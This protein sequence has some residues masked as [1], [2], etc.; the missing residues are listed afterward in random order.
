L[1]PEGKIRVD[2]P[3]GIEVTEEYNLWPIAAPPEDRSLSVSTDLGWFCEVTPRDLERKLHYSGTCC[4]IFA[5]RL[6][7]D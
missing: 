6:A 7:L 1:P 3:D 5:R 4:E 2:W